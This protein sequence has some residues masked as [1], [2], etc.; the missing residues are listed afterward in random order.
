TAG[1]RWELTGIGA[2]FGQTSQSTNIAGEAMARAHVGSPSLG[3]ALGAGAGLLGQG[4]IDRALYHGQLSAWR[5]GL[6]DQSVVDIS[7]VGTS[8]RSSDA[9]PGSAP[10]YA[11]AS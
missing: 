8:A 11:D 5:T 1:V 7:F 6:R 2:A 10:R 3:F 4:V 9:L